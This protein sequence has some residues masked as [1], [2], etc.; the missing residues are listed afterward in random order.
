MYGGFTEVRDG[1]VLGSG[2][3]VLPNTGDSTIGTIMAYA[4][5]AIGG[6]ALIS[7]LAA[8]VVRRVQR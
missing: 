5:I 4:A 8:R 6:T 2:I 3:V 1:V 7:H